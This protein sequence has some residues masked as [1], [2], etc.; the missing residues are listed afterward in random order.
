MNKRKNGK[1]SYTKPSVEKVELKAVEAVFA[2]S[3]RA[4]TDNP[5]KPR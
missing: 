4:S 1:R 5:Y 2:C 3:C